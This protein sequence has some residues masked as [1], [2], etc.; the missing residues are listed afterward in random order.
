MCNQATFEQVRDYYREN[1][2]IDQVAIELLERKVRAHLREQAE[3][4]APS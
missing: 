4:V 2:L 1:G 3:I